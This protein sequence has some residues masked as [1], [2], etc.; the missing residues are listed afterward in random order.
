M[1]LLQ[2]KVTRVRVRVRGQT[3]SALGLGGAKIKQDTFQTRFP[4]RSSLAMLN[5]SFLVMN[6]EN[7]TCTNT[8]RIS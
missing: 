6:Y 4:H 1:L 3:K 7:E 5:L 2:R 8:I